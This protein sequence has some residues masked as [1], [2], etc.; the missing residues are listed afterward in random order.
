MVVIQQQPG[1]K[2]NKF[3]CYI[4]VVFFYWGYIVLRIY[5]RENQAKWTESRK[6]GVSRSPC[7]HISVG[8]CSYQT[9]NHGNIY[10]LIDIIVFEDRPPPQKSP[11]RGA[12]RS[13]FRWTSQ[14]Y[15]SSFIQAT[16]ASLHPYNK[17]PLPFQ[18]NTRTNVFR[19]SLTL[20]TPT[21]NA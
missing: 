8:C 7:H 2:G 5:V 21:I 15:I 4:L 20:C 9:S 6:K 16:N 17:S 14:K 1:F 13:D 19:S 10:F 11:K 3:H 18:M 12:E